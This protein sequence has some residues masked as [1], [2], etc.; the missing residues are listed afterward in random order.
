MTVTTGQQHAPY[1]LLRL[2]AEG[3]MGR[4]YLARQESLDRLVA[5]KTRRQYTAHTGSDGTDDRE[6]LRVEAEVQATLV[7]PH[8]LTVIDYW[9]DVY[10]EAY[11][12]SPYVPQGSLLDYA[13]SFAPRDQ[14]LRLPPGLVTEIVS[15]TAAALQYAHDRGIVHCDIKPSNI[16]V[17]AVDAGHLPSILATSTS[18]PDRAGDHSL[19]PQAWR[20]CVLL[21]DFGLARA[22]FDGTPGGMPGTPHYAAPEV[23][24][25]MPLPA[26][27]QY[28]LACVAFLLLT[29][30]HVFDETHGPLVGQHRET[31][32]PRASTVHTALPAAVDA[33]LARAL[34]KEPAS[35]YMRICEFASA[36]L[37][38]LSQPGL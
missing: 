29:G 4:V 23:A 25:G 13:R 7:H 11:L 2:L 21:A 14:P 35:R 32:P 16:L 30:Q 26:T 1:R 12:V 38:A 17:Q 28:A 24:V 31:V 10:G 8:I 3:G 36:F 5:L 6:M 34:A 22:I 9:V 18:H 37:G 27:D 33:V 19:S 20:P 15:Q